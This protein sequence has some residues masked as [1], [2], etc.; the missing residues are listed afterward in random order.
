[1]PRALVQPTYKALSLWLSMPDASSP[2]SIQTVTGPVTA[3]CVFR[4][5]DRPARLRLGADLPEFSVGTCAEHQNLL[6][7]ACRG[8]KTQKR[9]PYEIQILAYNFV[10]ELAGSS[11]SCT[12]AGCACTGV[13]A[14]QVFCH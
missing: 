5:D 9:R 1:M 8:C 11:A 4:T 2:D 13:Q 6:T 3:S 10:A 14:P 12:R 7:A